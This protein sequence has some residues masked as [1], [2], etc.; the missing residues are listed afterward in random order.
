MSPQL[1]TATALA[2]VAITATWLVLRSFTKKKNSG[3]GGG[4]CGAVS[5]E[6]RKLQARLK[7]QP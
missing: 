6:V 5:P 1:Q 2:I 3:C 7:R 4:D